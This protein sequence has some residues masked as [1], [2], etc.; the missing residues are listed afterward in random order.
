[1]ALSKNKLALLDNGSMQDIQ[2]VNARGNDE[3][4]QPLV[5]SNPYTFV[6][7]GERYDAEIAVIFVNQL[8]RVGLNVKL[9]GIS[10]TAILGQRGIMLRP[11]LV[12][13]EAMPL[14]HEAICVVLPCDV[15]A[16]KRLND[17]PRMVA[18]LQEASTHGAFCVVISAD[19]LSTAGF[20]QFGY[21][22]DRMRYYSE[23]AKA[24][25]CARR[26][27]M[28]LRNHIEMK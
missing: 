25:E 2:L 22:A 27:G 18:F 9:V 20:E 6:M 21:T 8:R 14:V 19:A 15:A 17:D 28:E 5:S 24:L 16:L 3:V 26:V 10:G 11:D 4:S 1:M 7:W 13:G 23:T 12:L